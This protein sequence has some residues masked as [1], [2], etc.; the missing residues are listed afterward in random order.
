MR[1]FSLF[2]LMFALLV[3]L[4]Q[5]AEAY[6]E[7][8][9]GMP[10]VVELIPT[11]PGPNQEVRATLKSYSFDINSATIDW[12]LNGIS[13]TADKNSRSITFTTGPAGSATILNV[14][15]TVGLNKGQKTITIR[16]ASVNLVWQ[17][18]SAVPK[19]YLGKPLVLAGGEVAIIA[20]P[21]FIGANGLVIKPEELVYDWEKDHQRISNSS[22]LGKNTFKTVVGANS[23]IKVTASTPD[24]KISA[25]NSIS[26]TPA[27]PK[28][29]F[30]EDHPLNG[31]LT[32]RALIGQLNLTSDEITLLA[33]PFYFSKGNLEFS[34]TLNK[35]PFNAGANLN[36]KALLGKPPSGSG[37]SQVNVSVRNPNKANESASALINILFNNSSFLF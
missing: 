31:P 10:M 1:Y 13:A 25:I 2:V 6:T 4:G 14:T 32:N 5:S 19:N 11:E 22:G 8:S 12:Q 23:V 7:T 21:N 24:K 28:V 3:N 15:A 34:W 18:D 27:K 16:P 30:Y 33:M 36:N 20:L 37:Q 17:T 35:K 29:V 9:S 26:I